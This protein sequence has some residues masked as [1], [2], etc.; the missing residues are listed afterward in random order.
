MRFFSKRRPVVSAPEV[1][2]QHAEASESTEESG[3]Q[4]TTAEEIGVSNAVFRRAYTLTDFCVMAYP[5]G[6]DF[7]DFTTHFST[8]KEF[9]PNTQT[10]YNADCARLEADFAN[11]NRTQTAA[12]PKFHAKIFRADKQQAVVFYNDKEIIVAFEGSD[13]LEPKHWIRNLFQS[14]TLLQKYCFAPEITDIKKREA[15]P[16]LAALA[17]KLS[18]SN[19]TPAAEIKNSL[20]K[21]KVHGGWWGALNQKLLFAPEGTNTPPNATLWSATEAFVT[22]LKTETPERKLTFTGHSSGGALSMIAAARWMENHGPIDEF[23]SFGQPRV[24]NVDFRKSLYALTEKPAMPPIYRFE[25]LGDP[26]PSLP[27]LRKEHYV[28]CGN[29]VCLTHYGTLAGVIDHDKSIITAAE[30]SRATDVPMNSYSYVRRGARLSSELREDDPLGLDAIPAQQTEASIAEVEAKYDRFIRVNGN[31]S[32]ELNSR[33]GGAHVEQDW[34]FS[35]IFKTILD[36]G[37]HLTGK[38][39]KMHGLGTMKS[40]LGK[41]LRMQE[42]QAMHGGFIGH[43]ELSRMLGELLGKLEQPPANAIEGLQE[44]HAQL[45]Q[46][47]KRFMDASTSVPDSP[48]PPPKLLQAATP[49]IDDTKGSLSSVLRILESSD[50]FA[51]S[52]PLQALHKETLEVRDLI[53]FYISMNAPVMTQK[54]HARAAEMRR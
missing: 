9:G 28:H 31:Q 37:A 40:A 45:E 16:E 48:Q 27:P 19:G 41:Q 4:H 2:Q 17:E 36:L 22:Q 35:S 53:H 12:T 14:A 26:I 11:L 52:K 18:A 7:G 23:Y 32:A 1:S 5:G 15:S 51:H 6:K 24:G 42:L 44:K 43:L 20:V 21:A 54:E 49:L 50:N 30:A 47:I 33:Y 8:R 10:A 46:D 13:L 39:A 38:S 29:W 3:M 34:V 25:M